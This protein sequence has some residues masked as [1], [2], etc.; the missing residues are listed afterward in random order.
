MKS[1]HSPTTQTEP[2]ETER[3]AQ[4]LI[5]ERRQHI[6]ALAQQNGRGHRGGSVP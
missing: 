4:M 6:L 5:E 1:K 2:I 3:G